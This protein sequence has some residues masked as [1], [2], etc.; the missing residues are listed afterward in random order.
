M[1]KI[2]GNFFQWLNDLVSIPL[3]KKNKKVLA[4][5]LRNSAQYEQF[6]LTVERA[7]SL[8]AAHQFLLEE[9][10]SRIMFSEI[11]FTT[12]QMPRMNIEE[13]ISNLKSHNRILSNNQMIPLQM[14]GIWSL[15]I[16]T[17]FLDEKGRY[18]PESLFRDYLLEVI[19]HLT[20]ISEFDL[21]DNADH[22]YNV[23][24][25]S[26]SV[27]CYARFCALLLDSFINTL[28]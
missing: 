5:Q 8:I 13:V 15:S 6:H 25:L 27:Y 21:N 3:K 11:G 18:L 9:Y 2:F 19:Q 24:F 12:I 14:V 1:N 7:K 28:D 4:Y 16:S 20:Y 22:Q 26:E 17:F 10:D 23:R